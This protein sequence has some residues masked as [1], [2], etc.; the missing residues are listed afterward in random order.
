MRLLSCW[1]HREIEREKRTR[2]QCVFSTFYFWKYPFCIAF[3]PRLIQ[4]H[5]KMGCSRGWL[6]YYFIRSNHF[7]NNSFI[8][9]RFSSVE[10]VYLSSNA[11]STL[12]PLYNRVAMSVFC[13]FLPLFCNEEGPLQ[14]ATYLEVVSLGFSSTLTRF[15]F[16]LFLSIV[17]LSLLIFL[18]DD[19]QLFLFCFV[20]AAIVFVVLSFFFFA[21]Y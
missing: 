19:C 14:P 8:V 1:M 4:L 21:S 3:S 11:I 20:A 9:W 16:F 2:T 6:C 10:D 15:F 13:G 12:Q 18:D 7:Q 5:F 17:I